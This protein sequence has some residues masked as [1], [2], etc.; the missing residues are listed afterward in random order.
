MG[1]T[2][3]SQG[4][5]VSIYFVYCLFVKDGSYNPLAMK[6]CEIALSEIIR[7]VQIMDIFNPFITICM[8]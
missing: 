6:L 2:E 5:S 3:V 4:R 1:T 7:A 8:A